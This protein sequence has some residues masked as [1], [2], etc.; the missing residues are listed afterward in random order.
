MKHQNPSH[1]VC[2]GISNQG[3]FGIAYD[4]ISRTQFEPRT[5]F[6]AYVAQ[7]GLNNVISFRGCSATSTSPSFV[8]FG[9]QNDAL[10]CITNQSPLGWATIIAESYYVVD[11]VGVAVSGIPV[12]IPPVW[13]QD[14]GGSIVDSCTTLLV[15][16]SAIY[17]AFTTAIVNSNVLQ[18]AGMSNAM[19]NSFV[20]GFTGIYA[21]YFPINFAALPTIS[22]TL[23]SPTTGTITLTLSGYNYIQPDG[24]GYLFFPIG[25]GGSSIMFGGVFF[26]EYYIV[27]DRMN[28]R[29]GFGPGCDCGLP[30]MAGKIAT[31]SLGTGVS[32]YL[33]KSS[34]T[35][36]C[37]RHLAL[38]MVFGFCIL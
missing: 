14:Y 17:T 37:S 3:I 11:V 18:N 10:S 7:L 33:K 20:F 22:F 28:K 12:A 26:E 25:T 15:L 32:K 16:P 38:L 1:P 35:N 2:D 24:S 4:G 36:V 34:V 9:N 23:D 5:V 27:F 21:A 6:S 30:S 31:V 19:V 13:Q 29:I 8:D